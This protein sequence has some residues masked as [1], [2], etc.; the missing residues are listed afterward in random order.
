MKFLTDENIATSVV[1]DLRKKGF[2]VKDV[3]ESN[4]QGATD[5]ELLHIANQEQRIIITHDKDF[6]QVIGS[7]ITHKGII[8]MRLRTQH[9]TRVSQVLLHALDMPLA[10]KFNDK[11]VVVS[12]TTITIHSKHK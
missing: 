2:D 6:A 10:E 9:A 11:L 8:L 7:N 5:K 1:R 12:E 4:L 3:K